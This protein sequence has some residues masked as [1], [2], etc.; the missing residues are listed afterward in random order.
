MSIPNC[1][2]L[3]R[4]ILTPIFVRF[5]LEGERDAA[6]FLLGMAALSDILDGAIARR[7]NMITRLGKALDPVADKL[8][9]LGMM[10]C[11]VSA[12]PAVG[13]LLALHILRESLLG[14][15]GLAAYRRTGEVYASRW[16]GK[17]CTAFMYTALGAL[18]LFPDIPGK[19]AGAG[20]AA[21]GLLVLL[22]LV[23]YGAEYLKIL[24]RADRKTA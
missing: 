19:L 7:F 9:Q 23:L 17:L 8:L 2:T 16:Y 21:C 20:I 18:L 3:F 6:M 1:I 15:L 14:L 11:L 10:L 13:W 12:R 5:Y 22:C 4:I 24:K